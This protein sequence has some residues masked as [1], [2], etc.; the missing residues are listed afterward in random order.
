MSPR[1]GLPIAAAIVLSAATVGCGAA[2]IN[3]STVAELVR[4]T[5]EPA[6]ERI[7][8]PDRL[9]AEPGVSFSCQLTYGDGDTGELTVR[10]LDSEGRVQAGPRDLRMLTVSGKH[11]AAYIR[12]LLS[13]RDIGV[14]QIRCPPST[15]VSD[16]RVICRVVD[17]TGLT[18]MAVPR[19]EPGG[20]LSMD[21]VR[22]IRVLSTPKGKGNG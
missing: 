14:K 3:G 16:K 17:V 4:G 1:G 20:V 19:I 2:E 21:P 22:D 9:Q 11:A 7:E 13:R 10:V 8:C 12:E 6:P 15:R 18:A 5:L